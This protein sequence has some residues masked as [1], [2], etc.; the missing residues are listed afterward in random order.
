M[1]EMSGHSVCRNRFALMSSDKNPSSKT[2]NFTL[3]TQKLQQNYQGS[4]VPPNCHERSKSFPANNTVYFLAQ[5][6]TMQT[7]QST[8]QAKKENKN[9]IQTKKITDQMSHWFLWLKREKYE[10]FIN[11]PFMYP[12]SVVSNA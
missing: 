2:N 11:K 12:T 3:K 9:K 5:L 4:V 6:E 10:C 7:D 8:I 1:K